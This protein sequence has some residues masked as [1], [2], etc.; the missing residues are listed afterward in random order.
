MSD[1]GWLVLDQL[2]LR[3]VMYRYCMMETHTNSY[4]KKYPFSVSPVFEV[5]REVDQFIERY[6]WVYGLLLDQL[7][8]VYR[9]KRN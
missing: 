9:E 1:M 3:V 4:I 5:R 2:L 8:S 7:Q 6:E